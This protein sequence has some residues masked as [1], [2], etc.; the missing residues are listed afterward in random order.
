MLAN[1]SPPRQLRY[2]PD[3][4]RHRFVTAD[5]FTSVPFGGN[6][7]AVFPD[8]RGIPEHRLLDVTR[9][10]NYSETT[11]V[12]PPDDA[13][14]ARRVRIF[15]PG[16]EVPFAGHPTVGTAHA[17]AE[18]GEIPLTGELTRIVFEEKVG[19][20]P[21]SIRARSG[22]PEF[23]QLS[24][25]RLPEVGPTPPSRDELARVLGLEVDDLLGGEW[26]PVSMSCGLPFLFVPLHDRSAVARARIRMDAWE[27]TLKDAPVS[28]VMVFAPGG[29]RP[30][31]DYRAR[32]F[33]P[34]LSVPE[35]PATGSACAA[36]GGYL[37]ARDSRRDG[38]LRWV[39]E[40]GFEMGRP[41]IL[42]VEADVADGDVRAVR[43]GGSSVL[44]SEGTMA[45]R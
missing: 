42:E 16:G 17:L 41:S 19:P 12:Y 30:G 11:F 8:A 6:Q 5:V 23:V 4:S 35:D 14:H 21:V 34:A 13:R 37:A 7:L 39:V 22:R 44:V 33:A 25:A 28:E 15:T 2:L 38:T 24:V 27:A 36:L 1:R 26:S 3:M 10:F 9:E 32:M 18:T 43:V 45:I 29:E 31:T 40:Q 20:V